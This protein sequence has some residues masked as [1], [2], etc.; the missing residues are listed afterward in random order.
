M[1][2]DSVWLKQRCL[3]LRKDDTDFVGVFDLELIFDEIRD[4]D[5]EGYH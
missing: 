3:Q 5:L 1:V 4:Q 2:C